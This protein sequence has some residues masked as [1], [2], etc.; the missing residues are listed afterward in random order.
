MFQAR[1]YSIS[2]LTASAVSWQFPKGSSQL[3]AEKQI[4]LSG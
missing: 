4:A 2:K 3:I 1:Q